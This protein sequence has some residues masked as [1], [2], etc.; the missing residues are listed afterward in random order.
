MTTTL[1]ASPRIKV[2]E[3]AAVLAAASLPGIVQFDRR[4]GV[5]VLV[6][7]TGNMPG[8]Y[9][10]NPAGVDQIKVRWMPLTNRTVIL[11]LVDSPARAAGLILDHQ[12]GLLP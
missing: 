10:L 1:T 8:E 9:M 3:C 2:A 12:D 4:Y 11:G 7:F 6:P 5:H